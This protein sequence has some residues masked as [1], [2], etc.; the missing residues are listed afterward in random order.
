M[1]K[2]QFYTALS[3]AGLFLFLV[4]LP[5]MAAEKEGKAESQPGM[6]G[7]GGAR[8]MRLELTEERIERIMQMI[9][10]REPERAKELEQLRSENPE[11]FKKELMMRMRERMGMQQELTEERIGRIMQ[12]LRERDPERAKELEQLRSKNPEAFKKGLRETIQQYIERRR[13]EGAG[14]VEYRE[15]AGQMEYRQRPRSGK[16]E[17]GGMMGG[18]GGGKMAEGGRMAGG[19]GMKGGGGMAGG[20]VSGRGFGGRSRT[21]ENHEELLGWLEKN[22][23]DKAE[24]LRDILKEHPEYFEK[25]MSHLS[26]RYRRIIE[27]SEENPALA[28]VLKDDMRLKD[29]R[30]KLIDKIKGAKKEDKKALVEELRGVISQ[31]FD[32]II[33]RK[34]I[35]YEHLKSDLEDLKQEV[36]KGEQDI[37]NWEKTKDKRVEERVQELLGKMEEFEWN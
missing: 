18:M 19:G 7:S 1:N 34:R 21:Q 15:G 17:P 32:L 27:A 16:M 33:K 23:P 4:S 10:E 6:M 22:F 26:R 35:A 2:R 28:E 31:R 5:V 37:E 13:R 12:V 8:G 14:Q 3:A 20:V 29:M 9:R 25:A 30:W 11:A 36:K 24:R